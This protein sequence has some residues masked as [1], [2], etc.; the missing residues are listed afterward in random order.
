MAIP[1]VARRYKRRATTGLPLPERHRIYLR[2]PNGSRQGKPVLV[3]LELAAVSG[4]QERF[5]AEFILSLAEGLEM[6]STVNCH[7]ERR[8]GSC[9]N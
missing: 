4:I 2:Q 5:A 3:Q 6:T 9:P 8:E 7:P 1:F